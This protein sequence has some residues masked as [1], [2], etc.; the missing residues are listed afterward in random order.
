MSVA[1]RMKATEIMM[2]RAIDRNA[3]LGTSMTAES[4]T[5]TVM[6]ENSTALPAV[7]MVSDTASITGRFEPKSEPRKRTTM[8]S[9]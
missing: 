8:N 6:P 9:A 1:A 4:E 7:S 3:G 5:R 2:P